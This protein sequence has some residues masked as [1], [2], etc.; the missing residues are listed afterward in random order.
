MDGRLFATMQKKVFSL[1]LGDLSILEM[2]DSINTD[3]VYC[4]ASPLDR[5][6]LISTLL[7]CTIQYIYTKLSLKKGQKKIKS[8]KERSP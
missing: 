5:L 4:K 2:V 1:D 3:A 7:L 8:D 6:V